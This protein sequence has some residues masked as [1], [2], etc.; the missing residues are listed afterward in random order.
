MSTLD[1]IQ[2]IFIAIVVIAGLGLMIYV[3]K[4]DTQ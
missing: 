1:L 4:K 2:I 3:V